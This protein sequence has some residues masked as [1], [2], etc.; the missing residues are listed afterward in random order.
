MALPRHFTLR[1]DGVGELHG[2]AAGDWTYGLGAGFVGSYDY[3]GR[4]QGRPVRGVGYC[5]YIDCR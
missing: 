2:T 1:A 5:E 3:E 4:F